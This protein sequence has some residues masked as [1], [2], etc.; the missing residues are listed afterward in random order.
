MRFDS[1]PD[2][3]PVLDQRSMTK[4]DR[5]K[6]HFRSTTLSDAVACRSH[7]GDGLSAFFGT[8][9]EKSSFL[10]CFFLL[11][12]VSKLRNGLYLKGFL[13][14]C[15][16][17]C[18]PSEAS[19]RYCVIPGG[20]PP[21]DW[22]SLPCAGEELDS[23]PGLL[24]IRTQDYWMVCILLNLQ[25]KQLSSSN[26][27]IYVCIAVWCIRNICYG[28]CPFCQM[29]SIVEIEKRIIVLLCKLPKHP[30]GSKLPV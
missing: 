19:T 26:C 8:V 4:P 17:L 15:M 10:T 14:I 13:C 20:Y 3:N 11:A 12:L 16:Y 22:Q 23:N 1:I 29:Y 30:T 6:N 9:N 25:Y 27:S 5:E 18:R 2:P 7:C 24:R 28:S 21:Q